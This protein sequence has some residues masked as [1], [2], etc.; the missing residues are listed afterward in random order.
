[1]ARV[2]QIGFLMVLLISLIGHTLHA[3]T[4]DLCYGDIPNA[5]IDDTPI[6]GGVGPFVYQWQSSTDNMNWMPA[7]GDNDSISY[8][9]VDALT[10]TTYYRRIVID[11]NCSDTAMSNVITIH[12]PDSIAVSA[13][14]ASASCNGLSDGTI[15]LTVS[16]GAAPYT[17]DWSNSATTEDVT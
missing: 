10:D 3:Q 2:K 11:Q 5:F 16:G 15:D 4:V 6:T 7:S 13:V 9:P 1:M 12:V 17:Y 8:V 14:S